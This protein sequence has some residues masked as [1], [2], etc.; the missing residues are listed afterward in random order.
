VLGSSY[1]YNVETGFDS[2]IFLF[3]GTG[4]FGSLVNY[5]ISEGVDPPTTR[6]ITTTTTRGTTTSPHVVLITTAG[7]P[8]K[9]TSSKDGVSRQTGSNTRAAT[10]A[11]TPKEAHTIGRYCLFPLNYQHFRLI[12]YGNLDCYSNTA[13]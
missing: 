2:R 3:G 1:T 7:T 10:I 4:N 13:V 6:T 8:A 11:T 9:T 12:I 5:E